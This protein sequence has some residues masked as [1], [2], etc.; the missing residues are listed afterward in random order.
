MRKNIKMMRNLVMRSFS[1]IHL[2]RIIQRMK[3]HLMRFMIELG[4]N[5]LIQMKSV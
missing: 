1:K 4:I 3:R 5:S 2:E